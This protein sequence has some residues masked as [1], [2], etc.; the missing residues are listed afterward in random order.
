MNT[1]NKIKKSKESITESQSLNVTAELSQL[2][3]ELLQR[4][5]DKHFKANIP[6]ILSTHRLN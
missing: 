3:Y 2:Y 4:P 5:N 1:S 6:V